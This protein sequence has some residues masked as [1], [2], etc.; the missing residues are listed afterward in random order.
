MVFRR[1]KRFE[2][3]SAI[4]FAMRLR[5][6]AKYCEFKDIDTEEMRQHR[7]PHVGQRHWQL[8]TSLENLGDPV[9]VIDEET[10]NRIVP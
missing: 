5:G 2:G 4:E 10:F 6:L 3:E 8:A 7:E 9:N 1:A